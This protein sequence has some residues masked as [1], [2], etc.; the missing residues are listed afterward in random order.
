[1]KIAKLEAE[2]SKLVKKIQEEKL[3]EDCEKLALCGR[4]TELKERD[5]SP[6]GLWEYEDFDLRVRYEYGF[7][8]GNGEKLE[9]FDKKT[10]TFVLKARECE[11]AS[12]IK[13]K[14]DCYLCKYLPGDWEKRIKEKIK[15]VSIDTRRYKENFPSM[16][17]KE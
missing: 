11:Q 8:Y 12:S 3:L 10:N 4:Y 7:H 9:I 15:E 1:M 6:H 13:I 14:D 16:D 5:C 17:F 2:K